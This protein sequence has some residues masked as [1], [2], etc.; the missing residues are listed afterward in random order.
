[1]VYSTVLTAELRGRSIALLQKWI[2]IIKIVH[3]Q[4]P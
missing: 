3:G 1:M 4:K 2:I